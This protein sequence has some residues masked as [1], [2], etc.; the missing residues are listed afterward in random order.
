MADLE[1][2]LPEGS[3]PVAPEPTQ[4]PAPVE[5]S[6]VEQEA[7]TLGWKPESEFEGKPGKKWKSAEKFME[8][9]PLYDKIDEQHREIKKL[10]QGLD[11]FGKHYNKLEQAAYER[12]MKEMKAD[13]LTALEEGDLV[14]AEAIRDEMELKKAEA[15]TRPVVDTSVNPVERQQEMDSWRRSNDWYEKDEDMT[16]YADG[17]GNKLLRS[18]K[19]PSEILVEVARKTRAAFP[20]KFRNP[21]KESAPRVESGSGK[22]SSGGS[23]TA[24]MTATEIQIMESLIRSGAPITREGYIKDLKKAKGV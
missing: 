1:M 2:T 20:H 18:G 22:R 5:Y 6:E 24:G 23:D 11:A 4:A 8:D 19:D 17:V 16:A 12:A 15:T 7:M 3:E 10:K 21:N 14:R 13:R 9:K